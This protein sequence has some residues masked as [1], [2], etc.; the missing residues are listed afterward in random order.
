MAFLSAQNQ[1]PK[2]KAYTAG[3]LWA[4]V[5][6]HQGIK[7]AINRSAV[8]SELQLMKSEYQRTIDKESYM[9]YIGPN[10]QK[11]PPD[12][13]QN[14]EYHANYTLADS[15]KKISENKVMVKDMNT[16]ILKALTGI[17]TLIQS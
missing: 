5:H 8:I 12:E 15:P 3:V 6:N 16:F 2:I 7:A 17:L 10:G 14:Y 9:G 4:L 1:H 13:G 11:P